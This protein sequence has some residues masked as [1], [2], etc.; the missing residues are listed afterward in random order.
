VLPGRSELLVV[1]DRNC[2]FCR[3]VVAALLLWDRRRALSAAAYQDVRHW[4]GPH[5][6]EEHPG[7]WYAITER[8]RNVLAGGAA[9]PALFGRLPGGRPLAWLTRRFPHATESA[10][11]VV[12]GNRS[13]FGRVLPRGCV[14]RADRVIAT[15]P[16]TRGPRC[17]GGLPPPNVSAGFVAAGRRYGRFV[18]VAPRPAGSSEAPG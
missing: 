13:L 3:C 4:L 15:R 17:P 1:Y 7:S 6:S 2:G 14:K 16:R 11:Q 10:Y 18:D 8:D 5:G 12:A 9:F